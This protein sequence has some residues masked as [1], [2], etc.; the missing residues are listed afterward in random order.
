MA[1]AHYDIVGYSTAVQEGSSAGRQQCRQAAVQE[2][3]LSFLDKKASISSI[4]IFSFHSFHFLHNFV[5]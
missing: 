1:G 4:S 2:G 3:G 5:A